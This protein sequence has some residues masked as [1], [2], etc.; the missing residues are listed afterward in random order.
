MDILRQLGVKQHASISKLSHISHTKT[1]AFQDNHS[2][3]LWL[4][5]RRNV[6]SRS[7]VTPL[8]LPTEVPVDEE[9]IPGYH[10]KNFYYSHPGDMLDDRYELKA[11]IGWGTSS[12]V[13]LAQDIRRY[14][15]F[16]II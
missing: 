13:W 2:R 11:K 9:T 7:H 1:Y 10:P 15:R 16:L 5:R 8:S 14:L 6:A 3:H 12:T 4:Y